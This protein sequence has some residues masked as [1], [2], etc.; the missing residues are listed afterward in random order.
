MGIVFLYFGV[1][2]NLMGSS[3]PPASKPPLAG[4]MGNITTIG[5]VPYYID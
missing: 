3:D 4:A 1:G 5:F 2:L